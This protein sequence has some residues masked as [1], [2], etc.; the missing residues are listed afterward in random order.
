MKVL[1]L[2]AVVLLTGCAGKVMNKVTSSS[3][4]TVVVWSPTNNVPEAQRMAD[5]ECAKRSRFA[6]M[7]AHPDKDSV[8]F[9][10]DCVL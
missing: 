3:E 5:A 8:N 10:F 1:L 7:V 9:I 4:R 6:R 2:L